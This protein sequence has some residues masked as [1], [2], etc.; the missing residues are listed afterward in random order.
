V[1]ERER[2][3]E[4]ERGR[5]RREK[6]KERVRGA[7]RGVSEY[8]EA[9]KPRGCGDFRCSPLYC[10]TRLLAEFLCFLIREEKGMFLVRMYIYI[11]RQKNG[12]IYIFKF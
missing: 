12:S 6:A 3:R 5:H 10:I 1:R 7:E 9:R 11:Y 8:G 4:R 2:E